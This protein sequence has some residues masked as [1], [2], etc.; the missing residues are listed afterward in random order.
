MT[1]G[2]G[3]E[4][5]LRLTGADILVECLI[6]Q[7]VDTIFGFHGGAVLNIYDSLYKY[8]DRIRHILTSHEQGAAH[9]ADGYARASGK[10]GVCLATSGP[11]ATNLVTGIATAYMDS[12]PVVAITGNVASN[13][14]GKDSFQEVD[15]TGITMPIT[16]HNFMVKDV[17]DLAD[18]VRKAFRIAK[19]G[20][21]GP[22]LIDIPKDITAQYAEFKPAMPETAGQDEFSVSDEAVEEA[23]R[24]INASEKP[25]IYAGG[26]VIASNA[27]GQLYEFAEKVQC[28]VT[29][30]LMGMGAFP[31]TH[32]LYT[33]MVGMHGTKVSNLAVT[34]CDLLIAIV[35][36]FSDRVISKIERFAPNAKILHIDI[37]EA[38]VNKNIRAAHYIVGD[39]KAVLS[40]L[41]R[42][43]EPRNRTEW[44]DYVRKL[45]EKY[46]VTCRENGELTPEYILNRIYEITGGDAIIATEVGQHQIWT[47]Q[48]YKFTKP[49]TFISSGGLGTMGFGLGA[50]I[51]AYLARPDKRVFNIAGDG[52]FRMNLIELATAVEYNVPVIV[53]IMNNH[54]LGMVRQWQNLFYDRRYSQSTLDRQTDFVKLAEAFGAVGYNLTDKKDVDRVLQEALS[55]NR[56]VVIN[57]EISRDHKVWPMVPPGAAIEDVIMGEYDIR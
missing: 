41:N 14:I 57:C 34:Q 10:A 47:A 38:E 15:I 33:G 45:K 21:P 9:A 11:G 3:G 53:V 6:E 40:R 49:R 4:L 50:S 28:P 19:E 36:R 22:V 43:I 56:T 37:D 52:S 20:R 8:Q 24:L 35:A 5:K 27:A 2:P 23:V 31:A 16:K 32:E 51:G 39:V 18:I 55:L 26:G 46:Q 13:L 54:A 12:I 1:I 7:G 29:L 30:S 42:C 48:Y 17:N 25:M 44:L